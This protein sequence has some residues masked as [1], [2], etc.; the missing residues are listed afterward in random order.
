P[1]GVG[2]QHQ[3][4]PQGAAA[5][6]PPPASLIPSQGRK[7]AAK[8]ARSRPGTDRSGLASLQETSGAERIYQGA[9]QAQVLRKA[10]R[11][12]PPRQV[13]EG[14]RHPNRQTAGRQ[15]IVSVGVSR[16]P[17]PAL[18]KRLVVFIVAQPERAT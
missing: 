6:R 5:D 11:D 2:W 3:D 9:A 15:R 17:A 4:T 12:A 1:A 10:L 8:D 7:H 14:E 13:A 16:S 18:K